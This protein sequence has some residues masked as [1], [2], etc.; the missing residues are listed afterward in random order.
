MD[1]SKIFSWFRPKQPKVMP[2]EPTRIDR[3]RIEFPGGVIFGREELKQFRRDHPEYCQKRQQLDFSVKEHP[4][5]GER[6]I[7]AV[8]ISLHGAKDCGPI[9]G[10][11]DELLG[12]KDGE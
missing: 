7:A 6:G 1:W 2:V 10:I 8:W 11:L 5:A 3:D 4:A 9:P 12:D